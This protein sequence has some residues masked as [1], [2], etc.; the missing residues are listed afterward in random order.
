MTLSME[1][2]KNVKVNGGDN[3]LLELIAADPAFPHD[4]GRAGQDHGSVQIHRQIPGAGRRIFEELCPP[5]AGREQRTAGRQGRDQRINKA[6][7]KKIPDGCGLVKTR[8][9][10]RG[11]FND[12]IT[13]RWKENSWDFLKTGMNN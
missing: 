5:G 13:I 7:Q 2:G 4:R 9:G 8:G 1:A 3:N 12:P 11:F 10:W 6:I